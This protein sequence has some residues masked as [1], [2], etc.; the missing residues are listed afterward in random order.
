MIYRLNFEVKSTFFQR[1]KGLLG[2]STDKS[3][4]IALIP[5][6]SIHTFCMTYPL[7]IAILDAKGRIVFSRRDVK[8]GSRITHQKGVCTLERASCS[9]FWPQA[10]HRL[11]QTKLQ[12]SSQLVLAFQGSEKHD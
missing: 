5:C 3:R 9:A 4:P 7:D 10:T 12:D 11:V 6:N 8:P 2:T 1:L